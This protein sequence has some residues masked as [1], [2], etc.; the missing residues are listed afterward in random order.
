MESRITPHS[1]GSSRLL[2]ILCATA[3]WIGAG[4]C[5]VAQA[6]FSS[7]SDGT[8]GALNLTTPGTVVFDPS[9][10]PTLDAD[11]D[12]IYNFTTINIAAGVTV[13]LSAGTIRRP[14][15][16]LASGAVTIDGILDLDGQIGQSGQVVITNASRVPAEAGAGGYRGGVGATGTVPQRPGS[17][18]GGGGTNAQSGGGGAGHAGQG[19]DA[20]S[21]TGGGSAYGS[22][23]LTPLIGGSGGGGGWRQ[24]GGNSST[25]G[26]GGGGGGAILIA[27]S[28][29]IAVTGTI[30]ARG[31]AGGPSAGPGFAGGGG[32]GSGGSIR[33]A[34]P[35]IEG[36]GIL[37][38]SG[39]AGAG[40][41]FGFGGNG[42]VGRIRLEDFDHT[43]AGSSSPT[44]LLATPFATLVPTTGAPEV[45][46]VSVNGSPVVNPS[47]T[48]PPPDVTISQGTPATV[49]IQARN[50][51]L[52]A[53]VKLYLVSEDGADQIVTAPPLTGTPASSTATAT[54]TFPTGFSLGYVRA[55]W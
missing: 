41:N 50:V 38:A 28:A 35:H 16:W 17:G 29:S 47:G 39:G 46:V 25:G 27:S 45:H 2:L 51:P 10:F 34:A 7:G 52:T 1:H 33:L 37:D 32:G 49:D 19:G 31:G 6:Q 48:F 54:I 36:T 20:S 11:G 55:T 5:R 13:R 44:A 42:S 4:E 40:G 24:T 9:A 23:L 30:R 3:L 15:F 12:G 53:T 26:G 21:A 43:F 8:D 22:S 14:I 18:P